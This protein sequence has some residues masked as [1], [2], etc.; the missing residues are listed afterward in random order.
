MVELLLLL[1]LELPQLELWAIAPIL[2]LLRLVQLTHMWGVHH[3]VL[4]RSTARTTTASRS[5]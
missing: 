2:L 1:L 4:G 3:A 5:L